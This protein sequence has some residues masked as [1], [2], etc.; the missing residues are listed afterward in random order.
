MTDYSFPET[1]GWGDL[2]WAE[3]AKCYTAG[4]RCCL[5]NCV[6]SS[7]LTGL[8]SSKSEFYQMQIIPQ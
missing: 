7:E 6:H 5:H 1:R 3:G 2:D 8:A 4:L